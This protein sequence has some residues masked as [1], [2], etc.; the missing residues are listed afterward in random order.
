M[1]SCRPTPLSASLGA[2][3]HGRSDMRSSSSCW[4]HSKGVSAPGISILLA[5][6]M[7]GTG[8][9]QMSR[10]FKSISSSSFATHILI[11]ARVL[12]WEIQSARITYQ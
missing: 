12:S 2:I 10:C 5:K 7:I 1:P 11:L 3:C 8:L 6:N 4:L 9:A